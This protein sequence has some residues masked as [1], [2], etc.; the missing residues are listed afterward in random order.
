MTVYKTTDIG[1]GLP[2]M[3]D[4]FYVK[5][6]HTR[7][8][9]TLG[10]YKFSITGLQAYI[11][12]QPATGDKLYVQG[13]ISDST[14]F[15]NF[16]TFPDT[17]FAEILVLP[18]TVNVEDFNNPL[19]FSLNQNYPNPFNPTT[20]IKYSLPVRGKIRLFVYDALG[21]EVRKLV[22]EEKEAG[23]YEIEF[24]AEGLPSGIY[25]YRLSTGEKVVSRK[26]ILLK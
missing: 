3:I 26:M 8:N 18:S 17:G 7:N 25:V 14:I 13:F 15:R 5:V 9:D 2:D 20:T 21:R 19:A 12:L 23:K 16:D 22:D 10:L 6:I 1:Y 24:D 4:S 11:D